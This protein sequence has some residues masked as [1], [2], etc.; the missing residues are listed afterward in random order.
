M[1]NILFLV[2]IYQAANGLFMLAFPDLWYQSV[3][4]V[5]HTGPLNTHFVRDIGFG[6]LAAAL[7]LALAARNGGAAAAIWPGAVFLGGHA[8]LHLAEMMLHGIAP[9]AGARDIAIIVVP[10]LAPLAIALLAR[11]NRLR[12]ART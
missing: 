11:K 3:P 12:E 1:R 10:G 5:T 9:F 8:M 6:F 2:A 7:S 4:D